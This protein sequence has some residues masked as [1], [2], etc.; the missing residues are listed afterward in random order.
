[1]KLAKMLVLLIV[2]ILLP[3]ESHKNETH[4][5]LRMFC[6][7]KFTL[8]TCLISVGQHPTGSC[9]KLVGFRPIKIG[10]VHTGQCT[11]VV[12]LHYA[13]LL[14]QHSCNFRLFHYNDV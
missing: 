1:M 7:V 14:M 10:H 4:Y 9:R 13:C 3:D 8:P 6:C 2:Q 12:D 5:I 11:C